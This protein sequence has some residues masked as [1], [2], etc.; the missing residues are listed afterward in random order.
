MSWWSGGKT[1]A[2]A[3]CIGP[4]YRMRRLIWL[5]FSCLDT[6][7]PD[8]VSCQIPLD[9]GEAGVAERAAGA[10]NAG[11]GVADERIAVDVAA[12]SRRGRG[13]LHMAVEISG[14]TLCPRNDLITATGL[15]YPRTGPVDGYAFEVSGWVL[16]NAPV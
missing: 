3:N 7:I 8:M 4:K 9:T 2:T 6:G 13:L 1:T 16:S 14:V 5:G 11:E 12:K 15:D 10:G